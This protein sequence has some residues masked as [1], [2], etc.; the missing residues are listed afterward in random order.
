MVALHNDRPTA[1]ADDFDLA[2]FDRLR[3]RALA[4]P[5]APCVIEAASGLTLTY[6]AFYAATLGLRRRLGP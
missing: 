4:Q 2:L 6:G 5:D 1:Q 3:A